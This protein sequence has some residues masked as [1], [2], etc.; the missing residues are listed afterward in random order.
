MLA[1][2]AQEA[3]AD[4]MSG[5]RLSIGALV[6]AACGARAADRSLTRHDVN[7]DALARECEADDLEACESVGGIYLQLDPP[8]TWLAIPAL[9]K[10]CTRRASACATLAELRGRDDRTTHAEQRLDRACAPGSRSAC[11]QPARSQTSANASRPEGPTSAPSVERPAAPTSWWCSNDASA[12]GA[13]CARTETDCKALGSGTCAKASSV[14]CF[15]FTSERGGATESACF[16]T[17]TDCN[18]HYLRNNAKVGI[19]IIHDCHAR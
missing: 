6:L 4:V 11:E 1:S 9:E 18:R 16:P 19:T 2:D 10:A 14:T 15:W 13:A 17:L 5:N 12:T 3:R 7:V 8:E